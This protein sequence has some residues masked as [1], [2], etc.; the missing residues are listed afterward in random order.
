MFDTMR[1]VAELEAIYSDFTAELVKMTMDTRR[2]GTT[3]YDVTLFE[4][5]CLPL[6]N[7][8][9][10]ITSSYNYRPTGVDEESRAVTIDLGE[11]SAKSLFMIF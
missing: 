3:H 10:K 6:E 4:I 7:G 9:F 8:N 5:S 2:D 11:V 1:R